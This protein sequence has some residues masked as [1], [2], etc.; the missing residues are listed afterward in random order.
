[1]GVGERSAPLD[2]ANVFVEQ[3]HRAGGRVAPERLARLGRLLER[4]LGPPF[5]QKDRGFGPEPVVR[6]DQRRRR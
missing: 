2:G 6:T 1:M 3:S 4:R 5:G